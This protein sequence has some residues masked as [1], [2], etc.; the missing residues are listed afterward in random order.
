ML[1]DIAWYIS[2]IQL[3]K[4]ILAITGS[5]SSSFL[6]NLT[7]KSRIERSNGGPNGEGDSLDTP[8]CVWFLQYLLQFLIKLPFLISVTIDI[9]TALKCSM[10]KARNEETHFHYQHKWQWRLCLEF[11]SMVPPPMEFSVK[12]KEFSNFPR[13]T[14][15][16]DRVNRLWRNH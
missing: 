8:L 3:F 15:R 11:I 10:T 14:V 5:N 16:W 6:H 7:L 13:Q 12:Y 4:V 1:E 2:K 9:H